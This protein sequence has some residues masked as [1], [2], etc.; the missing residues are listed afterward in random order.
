ML[1]IVIYYKKLEMV[2]EFNTNMSHCN[3]RILIH[4]CISKKSFFQVKLF[5][6]SIKTHLILNWQVKDVF[7]PP[8]MMIA[9]NS[10]I[11]S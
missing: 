4:M 10:I 5:H 8:Q 6:K 1:N 2:K 3:C 7:W 9:M 11:R